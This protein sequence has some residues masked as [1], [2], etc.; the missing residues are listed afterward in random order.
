MLRKVSISR[1][2]IELHRVILGSV[3]MLHSHLMYYFCV[4]CKATSLYTETHPHSRPLTRDQETRF[5]FHSCFKMY[6]FIIIL[7]TKVHG[8]EM[9]HKATNADT[10]VSKYRSLDGEATECRLCTHSVVAY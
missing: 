6:L 2:F 1:F 10:C 5:F 8:K 9:V 3:D 7:K 4:T